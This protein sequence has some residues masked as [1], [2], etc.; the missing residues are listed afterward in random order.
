MGVSISINDEE[1]KIQSP[2][3]LLGG[4]FDLSNSPDLLPPLSILCLKTTTKN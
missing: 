3:E 4:T 1:I 2:E